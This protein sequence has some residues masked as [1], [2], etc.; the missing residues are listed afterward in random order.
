MQG[1]LAVGT[2]AEECW[3]GATAWET[4]PPG[5]SRPGPRQLPGV[6][7]MVHEMP[8]KVPSRYASPHQSANLAG[9]DR[10]GLGKEAARAAALARAAFWR[11]PPPALPAGAGGGACRGRFHGHMP[12]PTKYDAR[13]RHGNSECSEKLG[14]G[15]TRAHA[16]SKGSDWHSPDLD[17]PSRHAKVL[18]RFARAF[19]AVDLSELLHA[20]NADTPGDELRRVIVRNDIRVAGRPTTRPD[21][22]A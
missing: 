15:R 12:W 22:V 21:Q 13:C 9:G 18:N 5:L 17:L 6:H 16:V 3:A 14:L 7:A 4:K 11:G 1:A 20:F 19:C 8:C 10:D 2:P